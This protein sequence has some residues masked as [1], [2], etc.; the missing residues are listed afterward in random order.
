MSR[1]LG[2]NGEIKDI[3]NYQYSA[4]A[5]TVE[6]PPVKYG[7]SAPQLDQGDKPFCG[8]YSFAELYYTTMR[9]NSLE[10]VLLDPLELA[11]AYKKATGSN[12]GVYNT[13]MMGIAKELYKFQAYHQVNMIQEEICNCLAEGYCFI[14]GIPVYQNFMDAE[15]GIVDMPSGRFLGGHDILIQG[16]DLKTYSVPMAF[17][18]NHWKDWGFMGHTFPDPCHFRM[19]MEYLTKLGADAWTITLI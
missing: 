12:D 1:A 2:W 3:R 8:F 11:E 18:Q 16:Y 15:N 13:I 4:I 14:V 6:I 5:K 10:P 19:P 9:Q 17:G 7:W